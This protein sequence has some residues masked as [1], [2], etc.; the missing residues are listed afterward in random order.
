M[1]KILILLVLFQ[2]SLFATDDC[3]VISDKIGDIK[4]SIVLF[5]EKKEGAK[6]E[7]AKKFYSWTIKHY[8]GAVE[9]LEKEKEECKA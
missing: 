3:R 8:N 2:F 1:K 5:Q 9:I 7:W 4:K 6:S